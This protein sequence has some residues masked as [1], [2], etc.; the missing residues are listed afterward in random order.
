MVFYPLIVAVISLAFGGTVLAQ[1][2][3]RRRPQQLVWGVAL[4]MAAAAS[5]AF[6]GFLS[7]G[8][9]LLFRLYYVFGGLLMAAYLGM[10][11]LYIALD[12][13]V[14]DL[15]L[16]ALVIVS[17]LGVALILVAPI[18]AA[19]LHAV[20]HTSGAGSNVLKPGLWLLPLILL[21]IFGAAAVIGVALY[22]AFKV[23]RRQAPGRFAAANVTIAAGTIII[24]AAGSAARLG[25]PNLFWA[26][27]A[28]GWVVIFAGFLLT[29]SVAV[30][31]ARG[32]REAPAGRSAV[33]V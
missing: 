8:S 4:L 2:T 30:V 32:E 24:S 28:V 33:S 15:V 1:W 31:G 7:D 22:S 26:T 27:M 10:G 29:T 23:L 18:N 19:T 25:S 21:N 13:R 12:K 5:F 6:V 11:S 16:A 9:E 20:Q 3:R 14:A 17:A